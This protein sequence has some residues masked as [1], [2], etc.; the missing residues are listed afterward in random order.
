MISAHTYLQ[1]NEQRLET[2]AGDIALNEIYFGQPPQLLV[3]EELFDK[4]RIAYKKIDINKNPKSYRQ[5]IN[6]PI[7]AKIGKQIA[8]TF[9]FKSVYITIS[10]VEYINAYTIGIPTDSKGNNYDETEIPFNYDR[11][12][13]SVKITNSGFKIDKKKFGF[14]MLICLTFGILFKS[15]ITTKELIAVL[16][17]EIG[18][19]FSRVIYNHKLLSGRVDEK[20]AD[21]FAA[22]YGY[23]EYLIS[24]FSKMAIDYSDLEKTIKQ[25]P[26]IGAI[27]GINRAANKILYRTFA[28][29]EHPTIYRR[30]EDQIRH[31][32]TELKMS[33]NMPPEMRKDIE[34][35]IEKSK[36]VMDDFYSSSQDLSDAIVKGSAKYIEPNHPFELMRDNEANK[37]SSPEQINKRIDKIYHKKGFFR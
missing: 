34:T 36:K 20:F 11:L 28:Y 33:K 23:A 14:N 10:K 4:L 22:M 27:V 5:L 24:A 15:D 37:I 16:L 21:N 26:L 18:H 25:I 9:G 35:Q 1:E 7:L 8:D 6:D 2:D 17:H 30:M 3:V 31:L 12:V 29:D 32:E 13:G 19:Q